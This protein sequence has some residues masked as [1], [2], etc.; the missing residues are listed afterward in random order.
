MCADTCVLISSLMISTEHA[1][2]DDQRLEWYL[3]GQWLDRHQ[4][5]IFNQ[6]RPYMGAKAHHE[7]NRTPVAD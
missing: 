2:A 7:I 3:Y 1:R 6:A 5:P 4:R